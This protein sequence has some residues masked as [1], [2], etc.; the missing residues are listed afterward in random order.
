MLYIMSFLFYALYA[1]Q[2]ISVIM[3]VSCMNPIHSVVCFILVFASSSLIFIFLH[4]EFIGLVFLMVYV[5]AIAVLFI[6]VVMMLNV[7][8]LERDNTTYL[9]IGV[10]IFLCFSM[11]IYI[12]LLMLVPVEVV[13]PLQEVVQPLQEVAVALQEVVL[14]LQEVVLPLQ[15]VVQ[16]RRATTVLSRLSSWYLQCTPDSRTNVHLR[17]HGGMVHYSAPREHV[18]CDVKLYIGTSMIEWSADGI[19]PPFKNE[20]SSTYVQAPTPTPTY[21]YKFAAGSNDYQI[22]QLCRALI[23]MV[24]TQNGLPALR[25]WVLDEL[26]FSEY[27]SNGRNLCTR[28]DLLKTYMSTIFYEAYVPNKMSDWHKVLKVVDLLVASAETSSLFKNLDMNEP[29]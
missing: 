16:P 3:M 17:W 18:R 11:Q 7:K 29:F 15:E 21:G 5:G 1:L 24:R 28:R 14:P 22:D 13:L 6:F 9:L 23:Q 8:K 10:L 2:I 20:F 12:D 4:A 26:L 25:S 27:V 19:H